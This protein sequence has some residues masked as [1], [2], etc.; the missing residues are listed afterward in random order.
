MGGNENGRYARELAFAAGAAGYC[1]AIAIVT[2]VEG[3]WWHAG[4]IT[5]CALAFS[6]LATYRVGNLTP[7]FEWNEEIFTDE[8]RAKFNTPPR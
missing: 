3:L 1:L 4:A 8:F 2:A 6:L 7:R 5:I